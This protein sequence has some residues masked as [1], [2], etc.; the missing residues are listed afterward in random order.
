MLVEGI[1]GFWNA[2]RDAISDIPSAIVRG[3]VIQNSE[4]Q[5]SPW[6]IRTLSWPLIKPLFILVSNDDDVKFEKRV[7]TFYPSKWVTSSED[8][9]VFLVAA[10]TVAFGAIHCI[11]W[12]FHFPSNIERTLW[13][14]AS[15]SITGVPLV[16]FPLFHDNVGVFLREHLRLT[17][18]LKNTMILL[19]FLYILSR[20]A[21]LV[22]PF[23]C[24][25]SLP[26]AA[27]HVVH[28]ITFIPHI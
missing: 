26:P 16:I 15:P 12:S 9:S 8:F 4:F 27:F 18:F 21:L 20:L 24:L 17:F 5:D 14:V 1:V 22:L 25:R 6:L 13:H 28:W 19:L 11:V 7:D 2:L 23:L 3:P 10:I